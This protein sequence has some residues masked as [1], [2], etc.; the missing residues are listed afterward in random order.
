MRWMT[1]RHWPYVALALIA[2]AIVAT[3]RYA[4]PAAAYEVSTPSEY[5]GAD[6][7][8]MCH[9]DQWEQQN[10]QVHGRRLLQMEKQGRAWSCEGCHRAAKEHAE[11]PTKKDIW[12]VVSPEKYDGKAL[13]N[14]CLRCHKKTLRKYEWARSEHATAGLHC[15]RCH[16]HSVDSN[17]NHLLAEGA[18]LCLVCHRDKRGEF[19]QNSHHPVLFEQKIDCAD[20]HNPHKHE[21]S[22]PDSIKRLCTGCHKQQRGPYL[23]EHG[24][25]SGGLTDACLDCHRPHGSPN[26]HL[27]KLTGGGLCLSC[28][29]NIL[30]KPGHPPVSDCTSCH[31]GYHGSNSDPN[32]LSP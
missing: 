20:C 15:Y 13:A 28:H 27:L 12:T 22:D 9:E 19:A 26:A 21:K 25:I 5:A 16:N 3:W 10:R 30:A 7:C 8:K 18:T 1:R 6:T 29:A 2:G 24:A 17:R 11:N 31:K 32:L 4:M 14:M 23:Y